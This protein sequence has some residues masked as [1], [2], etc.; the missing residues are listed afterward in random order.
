MKRSFF[1]SGGKFY[2]CN[3]HCHSSI[4][5][6]AWRPEEIK[7]AYQRAG[8][9]AVAFTDHEVML[10]HRDLCDRDFV[11]LHGYETAV[12]E[13]P[14]THT[15][16]YQKVYHLNLLS[17]RADNDVQPYVYPDNMTPGNCRSHFGEIRYAEQLRYEHSV[18]GV[19]DLIRR[20]NEAGFYVTLNH[21]F[22]SLIPEGT[23]TE[24]KGLHAVEIGN[25][26]CRYHGDA[27]A[28]ALD[29]FLRRGTRVLPVGGD[30]NHNRHGEAD[31]FG[32]F[33]MLRA[34][35]LSYEGLM[36]GYG[37]GELYVSEGP[38]IGDI[39]VCEEGIGVCCT[40]VCRI[41]M[42]TEGRDLRMISGE[43]LTDAVFPYRAE[44]WGEY[45]R[46]ELIDAAGRHAWSRA[47]FRAEWEARR[48]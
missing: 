21:P 6:G 19:N 47:Y 9:A 17:R 31:S 11:A 7:A 4:S 48:S 34:D 23:Y 30:D 12:K 20:A 27:C 10:P 38:E 37:S 28:A 22:W 40:P 33:T 39:Y 24:L 44:R 26:G 36:A 8:Y 29:A 1:G 46:L 41:L 42:H 14:Y 35:E 16:P 2:K 13:D 32:Y 25:T 5:D 45:F 3:L 18:E 43:N 15:G